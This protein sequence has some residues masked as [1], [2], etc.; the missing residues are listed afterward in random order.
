MV[1]SNMQDEGIAAAT[2][3]WVDDYLQSE[4]KIIHVRQ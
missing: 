3:Q 1:T 2:A 4:K